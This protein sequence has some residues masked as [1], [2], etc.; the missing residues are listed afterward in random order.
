MAEILGYNQDVNWVRIKTGRA[1]ANDK[2]YMRARR[3]FPDIFASEPAPKKAGN[4]ASIDE[5]IA[6]IK[7]GKFVIVVDDERRENE[8]DLIMAAEKVTPE[9]INFMAVHARGLICAPMTG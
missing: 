3:A 1:P 4:M 2:F 9:A 8:G 6:D 5:A 7:S